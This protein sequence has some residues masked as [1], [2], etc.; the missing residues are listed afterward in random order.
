[1]SNN[2][3]SQYQEKLI[4]KEQALQ[5]VCNGDRI[6]SHGGAESF[7]TLLDDNYERFE[8][9][10]LFTMFLLS[11]RYRF[12]DDAAKSHVCHHASFVSAQVRQAIKEGQSP[13][14]L[15]AHF[16]DSDDLVRYRVKPNVLALQA[17]PMDEDGYFTMGFN[18]MG[19]RTAAD[20]AERIIVQ[21]N[22]KLPKVLGECNRLHISE[23]TAIYEEDLPMISLP[24]FPFEED[25]LKAA[26]RVAERIP[27][28]ATV[29]IGV[30]R[31]P[32]AIGEF[33]H[34]HKHLGVHT[35]VFTK[36]LME[37]MKEGV[38]DNSRKALVPGKA[39]FSFTGGSRA[40]QAIYDYVDNNPCTEMRPIS[41][42]ND[43]R[44]IAQNNDFVSVNSALAIDL[45]GQVCSE[46]IGLSPFSGTGGQLDFVRGARWA[47][48]GRSYIVLNSAAKKK[49][50]SLISK[51]DL[52]LPLG[53]A[54]TT[55]RADVD[56]IVT[57][58]GVAELRFKSLSER[59]KA[60]ISIAHPQ[61]RDELRFK[62]KKAGYDI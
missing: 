40:T 41:W 2:F 22:R 42:V 38:I 14:L 7:L 55:P 1:M 57:E 53:S 8:G 19:H 13:E 26:Q 25:D 4:A 56:A 52:T 16:S 10:E 39:V 35:E 33:L 6:L 23:V 36:S 11:K 30:G 49:D 44:I 28:G 45:T 50:G 48:G 17:T 21:V 46:T 54:V 5:L 43:P 59:A 62:A 15:I 12:L 20:M 34:E 18:S 60:L 61:F 31:V 32:D 27:N 9:I 3:K 37:L 29:Q 51:I 47:E 24:Q 58:Y